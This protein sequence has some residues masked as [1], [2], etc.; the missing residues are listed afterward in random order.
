MPKFAVIVERMVPQWRVVI[1]E[2]DSAEDI[3]KDS[4]NGEKVWDAACMLDGWAYDDSADCA[5]E[6]SAVGVVDAEE[7]KVDLEDDADV[8]L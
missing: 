3:S 8:K 5:A 6:P 4:A 1:V 7:W 2:A